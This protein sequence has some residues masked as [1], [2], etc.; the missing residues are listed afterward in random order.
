MEC[1]S[2]AKSKKNDRLPADELISDIADI[3][4]CVVTEANYI[5]KI[6]NSNTFVAYT[7]QTYKYLP[8]PDK[9]KL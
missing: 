3:P 9:N 8:F 5:R 1:C 2:T 7:K 4:L 6:K